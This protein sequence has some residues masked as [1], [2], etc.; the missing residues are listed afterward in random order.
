MQKKVTT[1]ASNIIV[2]AES[3]DQFFA[4]NAKPFLKWAGGKTQLL[5]KFRKLYPTQLIEGKIKNYYEP[6]LGSGAVFFDI[7]QHYK[8][9]NAYLY[10]INEELILAYKVIQ[11]DVAKLVEYLFRYQK[12][13]AKLTKK[14]KANYFYEQRVNYNLQRFNID[15]N[16]YS[17]AW[18]ARVAQLIFLNR[19]CFNGLF[20]VNSK[21]EFNTPAGDY[22]NPTICDENNLLSVAKVLECATIKKA[23][24][25]QLKRVIRANSFVYFDP[26]YRPI[27]KSASFTAYSKNEFAD[28]EQNQLAELFHFLNNKGTLCMLSNSDPKNNDP[29]DNFFDD[30]YKDYNI[31]R[32]PAKRMINSNAEKRGA[33]NEIVVTNYPT[34]KF[35]P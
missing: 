34:I 14:Q 26:P 13:Y 19:T 28:K 33:I 10:D 29:K 22:K 32:V 31:V 12:S 27:S 30:L 24:F 3:L 4:Y 6:F 1:D 15:Y 11:Q 25:T 8:I 9:E 35:Q 23:D 20:R 17:E 5:Q 18:I 2:K 21:G 7:A 16:K